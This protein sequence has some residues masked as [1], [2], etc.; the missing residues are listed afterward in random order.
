[1]KKYIFQIILIGVII[2]VSSCKKDYLNL[3][4]VTNYSYYNFPQNEDQVSQA[5]VACYA[6]ARSMH[7]DRLWYFGEFLSDNTSFNYNPSDRGGLNTEALDEMV[8]TA[9]DGLIASFWADSYD[10]ILRCNYALE[11]V[12][13]VSF[14]LPVTKDIRTGEAKFWRAWHYFNLVRLYGDVPIVTKVITNPVEGTTYKREPLSK[15]YESVIIPDALEAIAKL[16]ATATETGRLTKGAALMLL[17][18]VYMTQKKFS[19]AVTQLNELTKLGY[20]LNTNFSDN[21][22]PL[23]KNS[24][25]S[26]LEMQSDPLQAITFGFGGQ[27]TPWG[28][29]T[30]IWPPNSNSRGGL[31]QPTNDLLNA[32]EA[33]DTRKNVTI[34]SLDVNATRKGVLYLK[35]FIVYDLATK[36]NPTNFPTYRYSDAL[37]M[38]SEC[39]NEQG[40]GNAQAFTLLNQVRKRAGLPEKNTTNTPNQ[41]A[42]RLA[43]E[44]ERQVELAGENHRWYDLLRTDRAVEVMTAHGVSE[45]KVK[46]TL[47]PSAYSKI[48]VLLAIPSR[49]A[50]QWGYNQNEGW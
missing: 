31:N 14:R 8:N 30:T 17:S 18:K 27:F 16:P 43:I 6:R 23:K 3:D 4:P 35:K 47:S 15:A 13:K 45:R 25:E 19:D 26:I 39:L 37:L 34:G 36:T 22:D 48:R 49:E 46:T 10:G 29:G 1:M 42:F 32:Y 41:Q 11:N 12:D 28:T 2:T 24:K 33:N 40:Y 44:K 38:L 5:V 50:K 9:D 20:V 21:F 7:N